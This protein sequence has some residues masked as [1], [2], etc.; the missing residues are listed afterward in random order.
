MPA[1]SNQ[2][3]EYIKGYG[4]IPPDQGVYSESATQKAILGS[5]LEFHDGRVFRYAKAGAT[6]LAAGKF[7]KIG[8]GAVVMSLNVTVGA[9]ATTGTYTATVATPA[10]VTT[11]EEGYL[12]VN[13]GTGQ[14]CQYKIKYTAA[15]ADTATSTDVTLYDP[16][17]AGL[18]TSSEVTILYNPY[19]QCE[20]SSA[21]TDILIGVTPIAVTAEYY[22]W[23]QTWGVA[24]VVSEAATAAGNVAEPGAAGGTTVNNADSAL[25]AAV[26][27]LVGV[28]TEFKPVMLRITP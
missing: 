14:G 20:V 21:V 12:Q 19:E 28:S 8:A 27:M 26:M 7:M 11:L 4:P 15:N 23:L 10:A 9:A 24:C 2:Y 6:A 18:L 17:A 3:A 13:D 5:R 25:D 22:F 16:L 1:P